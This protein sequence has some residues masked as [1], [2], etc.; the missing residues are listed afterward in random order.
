[1]TLNIAK[2]THTHT[3]TD[4]NTIYFTAAFI[5]P[6]DNETYTLNIAYRPFDESIDIDIEGNAYSADSDTITDSQYFDDSAIAFITQTARD[7]NLL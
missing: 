1:M 5:E 2:I 6:D 3:D 4:T 7:H